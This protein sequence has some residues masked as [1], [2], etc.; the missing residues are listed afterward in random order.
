MTAT[1][2]EEG[3]DDVLSALDKAKGDNGSIP[4]IETPTQLRHLLE[5]LGDEAED[6]ERSKTYREASDFV[7]ALEINRIRRR[8]S[9]GAD[10]IANL[11]SMTALMCGIWAGH[12]VDLAALPSAE[13]DSAMTALM[14]AEG[15]VPF[16]LLV[17]AAVALQTI[18]NLRRTR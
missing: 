13:H 16:F 1:D 9:R 5:R 8:P 2:G 7:A 10:P 18:S 15:I 6:E 14:Q 3:T 17:M 4:P 11:L 12:V